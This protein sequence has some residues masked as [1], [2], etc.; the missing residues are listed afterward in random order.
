MEHNLETQVV[1]ILTAFRKAANKH[2]GPDDS[3]PCSY[4]PADFAKTGELVRESRSVSSGG[5]QWVKGSETPLQK[6]VR[7][8]LEQHPKATATQVCLGTG[9]SYSVCRS[10]KA[11]LAEGAR[12]AEASQATPGPKI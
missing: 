1:R 4:L 7:E 2:W 6:H 3:R 10:V 5:K 8:Y 11:R 12:A 9:A